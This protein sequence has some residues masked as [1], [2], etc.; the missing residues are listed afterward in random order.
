MNCLLML[1]LVLIFESASFQ[2]IIFWALTPCNIQGEV[3]GS[4]LPPELS[5]VSAIAYKSVILPLHQILQLLVS[6]LLILRTVSAGEITMHR[7]V[8]HISRSFRS[9]SIKKYML[10][11][12]NIH[13]E[14]TQR[15]MA[16]EFS[17][18]NNKIAIQLHLVA[19][20]LPLALLLPDG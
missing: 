5:W 1:V 15:V 3:G 12:T 14:A 7:I 16:A 2:V 6:R 17:R 8:W 4:R 19:E 11:T 13:W 18:L 9:E 20:N 10:T